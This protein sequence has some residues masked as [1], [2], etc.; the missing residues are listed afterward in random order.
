MKLPVLTKSGEKLEEITL[1]SIFDVK[2][3]N[4]T[5]T[6]YINYLRAA[7]HYPVANTKNR[8]DV[9][10]GGRKP[11]RQKGTGNARV[12]S[13]RSPLWVG[14]GVTFGPTSE[15]NHQLRINRRVRQQV[16]M[17]VLGQLISAGKAVA[18]SDLSD[19][20]PKTKVA[21]S[22]LE[23]IEAD[24]KITVVLSENQDNAWL[25]CRNL[26][27]V[28]VM[29]PNKL[30]VINLLSTDKLVL[31]VESVQMI[32][33]MYAQKSEKVSAKEKND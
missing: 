19:V 4:Q 2:V 13:T 28:K 14:G 26:A 29:S 18:I 9:S 33:D 8:G 12:G 17:S 21:A 22:M 16:V 31:S 27:G 5:L 23:K 6:L 24:G 7:R 1:S 15:R 30:D 11:W 32:E 20:E 10:G 25:S 3:S